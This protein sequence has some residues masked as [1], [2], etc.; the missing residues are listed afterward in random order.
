MYLWFTFLED[1]QD[2]KLLAEYRSLLPAT[3]LQRLERYR[4][5]KHRKQYLVGRALIRTILS[6]CT[7]LAPSKIDIT[8]ED[9][10]RPYLLKSGKDSPPQFNLSYTDGL[11]AVAVTLESRVGIDV[12]NTSR[13]TD[14]LEIAE[15]YFSPDEYKE[16][17]Q[18]P[19]PL[20]KQRFFEFWTLKEA[21]L[22]ARGLGLNAPL[23]EASF[24]IGNNDS[25]TMNPTPMTMADDG[26]WHLRM[27]K[28]G[29]EHTAAFCVSQD[30]AIP[31]GLKIK[32]AIPLESEEDLTICA[33]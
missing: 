5:D 12:E 25:V 3:E 22:K 18:L 6:R 32:K 8:R 7:A 31:M 20:L 13:E 26:D 33:G 10:G 16:L 29:P 14:C 9:N 28:P 11:V 24:A 23:A 2:Q 4:F 30:S 21:Y 17:V 27:L 1:I 15:R 19:V